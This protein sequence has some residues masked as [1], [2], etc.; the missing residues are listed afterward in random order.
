MYAAASIFTT[1]RFGEQGGGE[2]VT[3]TPPQRSLP[4]SGI[5]VLNMAGHSAPICGQVLALFGA[6]VVLVEGE[7]AATLRNDLA[8]AA[9]NAGTESL[10]LDVS[11]SE[12]RTLLDDLARSADVFIDG[13]VVIEDFDPRAHS[14]AL[15]HVTVSPFGLEG[16]RA[17]WRANE[18]V[19][20]ASGGLLYLSG[21]LEHPPAMLGFPLA[22]GI[23]GAQAAC[24]VLIALAQRH[25]TGEGARIDVS[26]QESVVNTLY[27]THLMSHVSGQPG[28][29]G[30]TPLTVA[31]RTVTRKTLWE[32]ADGTVTWNIWMGLGM[33]R[34]NDP[35]FEWIREEGV[36]EIEELI[37]VPWEEL[38]AHDLTPELMDR[39][40]SIVGDF[41][42]T[43]SKSL[44]RREAAERKMLLYVVQ[45]MSDVAVDDQL[46]EREAFR[47]LDLP[48]G[49]TVQVVGTPVRSTAY[50]IEISRH[51][52]LLGEH[53]EAILAEWLS[54]PPQRV[55]PEKPAFRLPFDGIRV[56]D[57]SWAVVG[58]VTTKYLAMFGADVVKVEFRGRPDAI[59]MTGPYPTGK[60]GMNNSSL[61]SSINAGKRSIGIDM[62]HPEARKVLHRLAAK[63]DV[64]CE[65]FTPGTA[66]RH[67]Y[68][69]ETFR[70]MRSDTIMMSLS[71]QGQTGCR[72]SQPGFGNHLQAMSGIDSLTGFPDGPPHGPNQVLPDFI[73]PWI[74]LAAVAAALEHR[75]RTG[76]GQYIDISQF[77][78]IML[79]LQ[80]RLIEFA[81]SGSPP[82][83]AGNTSP[84][85]SPHGVYPVMGDDQWIALAVHADSEWRR[86]HG[87]LPSPL[88]ERYP[89]ALTT[90]QRIE[91]RNELDRMLAQW[92]AEQ[93]AEALVS[94]LQEL[95]IAAYTVSDGLQLIADP[96][97]A[98]RDHFR[99]AEHRKLGPQIVDAPAFRIDNI[100][101]RIAAGPLYAHD[102]VDVL[103]EWLSIDP[104]ELADLIA[105]EA[106][107]L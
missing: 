21:D 87:L 69:Y 38:G 46:R 11:T 84:L 73:G 68:S 78:A 17:S 103:E 86:L 34:K 50:P 96:Q 57:F 42:A 92:T 74:S 52:P 10:S 106:L 54:T 44:I 79:Y 88:Q 8:W 49:P 22:T 18:L 70:R 99:M 105:S 27:T 29:R 6:D 66:E 63:A 25:R 28:T 39:V 31:G 91:R 35:M 93:E 5:R 16:P 43:K 101:P 90:A 30:E 2:P 82:E 9:Y 102:T 76:E 104:D 1:A 85:A 45:D 95:K 72:A 4:L 97:L 67:G 32:C 40:N 77:E 13:D 61:F 33:G 83:R 59:R 20:Q 12:G 23:A 48:E 41:L 60:P 14:P 71:M 80:P 51:V 62:N 19:S 56:L 53:T 26:R 24:A 47:E 98:F 36:Q 89:A 55:K 3:E 75:R 58:P 94:K 100:E 7:S 107:N 64:I 81:I 37:A 15:I 65:N